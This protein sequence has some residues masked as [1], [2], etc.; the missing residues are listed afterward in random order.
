M[1]LPTVAPDRVSDW[2]AILCQVQANSKAA[3]ILA[4]VKSR[5]DCG[6]L[7]W[8][9]LLLSDCTWN[10]YISPVGK[11]VANAKQDLWECDRAVGMSASQVFFVHLQEHQDHCM[12]VRGYEAATS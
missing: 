3:P 11:S 7:H 8:G 4:I 1:V 5:M 6:D 12:E 2:G 9:P 10:D